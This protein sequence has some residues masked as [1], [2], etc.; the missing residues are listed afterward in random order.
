MFLCSFFSDKDKNT[1][2][3]K[4]H[5]QIHSCEVNHICSSHSLLKVAVRIK[6]YSKKE[7]IRKLRCRMI[8]STTSLLEVVTS[9]EVCIL[10]TLHGVCCM[11]KAKFVS[12]LNSL[13]CIWAKQMAQHSQQGRV[14]YK[15][16]SC[17]KELTPGL[18]PTGRKT[19]RNYTN[20]LNNSQKENIIYYAE[21]WVILSP[22]LPAVSLFTLVC[23]CLSSDHLRQY[24]KPWKEQYILQLG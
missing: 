6:G 4:K 13:L 10:R 19:S 17:F 24:I 1:G 9:I 21:N 7:N 14:Y 5:W 12:W 15:I 3:W 20:G 2:L 16:W 8:D 18:H 22:R 23:W 11:C